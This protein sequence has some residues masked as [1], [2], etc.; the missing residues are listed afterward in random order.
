MA[1]SMRAHAV[2]ALL[3]GGLLNAAQ[4]Q[5]IKDT[6]ARQAIAVLDGRVTEYAGG[7]DTRHAALKAELE[8]V[9]AQLAQLQKAISDI[10]A[11][12]GRTREDL[13]K[14]RSARAAVAAD[15][16]A[17]RKQ[18][19]SDEASFGERIAGMEAQSVTIDGVTGWARPEETRQYEAAMK[20]MRAAD[21]A[22]ATGALAAF[23][24]RYPASPYEGTV[25]FWQGNAL[26]AQKNYTE[27][28]VVLRSLVNTSPGHERA[29]AA[30][31]AIS[32]CLVETKNLPAARK[33]LEELI[34]LYPEH[35]TAATAKERLV[36]LRN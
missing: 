14:L 4:A 33:A 23:Q 30:W 36:L 20:P 16:A 18:G 5:L 8:Q 31:L 26:Y 34:R 1:M 9:A 17:V 6:E 22:A 7:L 29:P 15:V 35:D 3:L 25:R 11:D 24:R 10:G 21:Y 13:A 28:L 19:A 32:N 2:G 12:L 27:A